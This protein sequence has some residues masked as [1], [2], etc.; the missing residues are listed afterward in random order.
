MRQNQIDTIANKIDKLPEVFNVAIM[1]AK[2]LDNPDV[3]AQSLAKII[4]T[5]PALT[6]QLLRLC[7]SA[8]YGFSKKIASIKE[9]IPRLG[10]KTLKSLVFLAISQGMLNKEVKG[11]DLTKGALWE[12]SISC[13]VYARY[14]AKKCNY[15]D[16]EIAFTAGLLRDIGKLII[17]EYVSESYDDIIQE[18]NNSNITFSEAEEKTLGFNHSEIGGKVAEKWNFPCGLVESIK[19]HHTPGNAKKDPVLVS[20]VHVADVLTMMLG[21]GIGSDGMMYKIE[22]NTLEKLNIPVAPGVIEELVSEIVELS[23]E[24]NQIA[25]LV[26][27]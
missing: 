2:E 1:V 22:M 14:L 10:F 8:Q 19:Y 15:H 20:I 25:G 17:H 18:V 23:E 26:N 9:A 12:N 7:N 5:D 21:A 4:S 16:P 6:T 24:V 27:G 3:N 13:A 11:Y